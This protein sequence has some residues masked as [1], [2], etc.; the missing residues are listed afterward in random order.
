[1]WRRGIR[2]SFSVARLLVLSWNNFILRIVAQ[3][4]RRCR[5]KLKCNADAI[6]NHVVLA[7]IQLILE[8]GDGMKRAWAFGV[9][10]LLFAGSASYRPFMV[11]F[12]Q[13]LDF[14]GAQIGILAGITPLLALISMPLM[15]GIADRTHQ[16]KL[17]M[18]L[19]LLASVGVLSIFPALDT[20]LLVLG[21]TLLIT[22]FFPPIIPLLDSATMSILGDRKDLYSRI[23]LGGTIGFGVMATITGTL[24]ENYGLRLAFWSA[25]A[26]YF[27]TLIVSQKLSHKGDASEDDLEPSNAG[28]LLQNPQFLLFL[29]IG[30]SGGVAFGALNAYL[31][32]YMDQLGATGTVMGLALTIGTIAEIPVLF[33]IGRFIKQFGAYTLLLVSIGLTSVR[34]FLTAIAPTPEFVLAAQLLNGFNYPLLV[35]AGVTYADEHAPQGFHATAQGLF[36][37]AVGGIGVAIGSFIGGILFDAIGPRSMYVIFS[38][39]IAVVLVIVNL[40][41]RV[42]AAPSQPAT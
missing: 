29:F 33:F 16:H 42:L 21:G 18:S 3:Y 13:S 31:F 2:L 17:V 39:Y 23:R 37:V 9:Y 41:Q 30:I 14:T 36:T 1:M 32:P 5:L 34:L 6:Y 25:A 24:V 4:E 7:F 11:L 26:M 28:R 15:T 19:M 12:Y 27:I 40:I 22:I 38:I 10:V 35:V 8:Y 20:F